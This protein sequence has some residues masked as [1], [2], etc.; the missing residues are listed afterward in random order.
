MIATDATRNSE[1]NQMTPH[2]S[3]YETAMGQHFGRLARSVQDF[4]R[5][6]GKHVLHGQVEIHAPQSMP[7]KLIARLLGT[8]LVSNSGPIKF[9]LDARPL[10]ETWTRYFPA[11]AMTSHLQLLDGHLV[12]KL[13]AARLTFALH[14]REGRLT[15]QLCRLQFLGIACP[16]WLMPI[17]TAEETGAG[18]RFN[19]HVRAVV[20]WVGVVASY[21]GYL[22]L[23]DTASP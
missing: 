20:P 23:A 21:R 2:R 19:F 22:S 16:R 8:P 10:A 9:E 6:A 1:L 11:K 13:G 7:A 15:M 5:L 12:E 17:V 4:H 14:E 3:M 18:D